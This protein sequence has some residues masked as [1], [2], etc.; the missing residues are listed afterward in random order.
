[1]TKTFFPHFS[2][3]QFFKALNIRLA[4]LKLHIIFSQSNKIDPI[5]LFRPFS[6]S[7]PLHLSSL[8]S[9]PFEKQ[10]K[11]RSLPHSQLMMKKELFIYVLKRCAKLKANFS[12]LFFFWMRIETFMCIAS[13]FIFLKKI[14]FSIF[15]LTFT[16]SIIVMLKA[17]FVKQRGESC[18]NNKTDNKRQVSRNLPPTCAF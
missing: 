8:Y 6:S 3:F 11:K 7:S 2:N 9:C 5:S 16:Q 13:Y 4:I 15:I 17:F 12:F 10:K 18:G 1:M 14:Y